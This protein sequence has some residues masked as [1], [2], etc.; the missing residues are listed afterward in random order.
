MVAI[1]PQGRDEAV[2]KYEVL[3][4]GVARI[5]TASATDYV[6]ASLDGV[7]FTNAEVAF[8]G[9]AGAVRIFRDEVHLSVLEGAGTVRYQRCTLHADS[10]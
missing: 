3:A 1:F 8:N 4:D 9:V 7:A 2:P 5:T 6:F 10:P